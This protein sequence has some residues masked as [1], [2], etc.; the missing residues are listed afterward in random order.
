VDIL[1]KP[2][3]FDIPMNIKDLQKNSHP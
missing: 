1:Q 2:P 3:I